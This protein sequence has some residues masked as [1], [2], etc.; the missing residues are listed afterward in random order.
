VVALA[1]AWVVIG[2]YAVHSR[3]PTNTLELP[4]ESS[5]SPV[6][7]AVIPEGWAF[8]TRSPREDRV[9]PF[10]RD[11]S[12]RWVYSHAGPHSEPRNAFGL[13][14]ASRAQG[15]EL[16]LLMAQIPATHWGECSEQPVACLEHASTA[17]PLRN[18]SPS[19]TLCGA[20][21]IARQE[22]LPWAWIDARDEVT[23]PTRTA[24]LDVTC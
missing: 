24:R 1:L 3:F 18:E 10:V 20:V 4:L 13:N 16:G 8:F 5:L 12:G 15:V 7:V 2:I 19:P 6:L 22:P 11:L 9:M 21:G 17:I 23:M 14:R